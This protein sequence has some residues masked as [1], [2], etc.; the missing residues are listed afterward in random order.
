MLKC[1]YTFPLLFSSSVKHVNDLCLFLFNDALV[2]THEGSQFVP[3]TRRSEI[4]YKF[5]VAL[6]LARLQVQD[7]PDSKCKFLNKIT[8]ALDDLTH[9]CQN[10]LLFRILWRFYDKVLICFVAMTVI[11]IYVLFM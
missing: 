5:M 6:S 9:P 7:V 11:I 10:L 2:V 8:K 1:V 3:Y 4:F